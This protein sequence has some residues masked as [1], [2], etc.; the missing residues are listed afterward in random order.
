MRQI[1]RLIYLALSLYIINAGVVIA[2]SSGG[3]DLRAGI[4]YDYISQEY[5]LESEDTY[6]DPDS[7]L[8][9]ALLKKD[10]L[11][12]KKGFFYLGYSS[13]SE[14]SKNIDQNY[15]IG[16]EQTGE[17]FRILGTARIGKTL[18]KSQFVGNF[19]LELKENYKGTADPGEE[20]VILNSNFDYRYR[21]SNMVD[22]RSKIYSESVRFDTVESY[23]YNYSRYGIELGFNY[24]TP[25]FNSISFNSAFEIRD[26]PDSNQLDYALFRGNLGYF[27]SVFGAYLTADLGFESRNYNQL[28][29]RENYFLISLNADT[30]MPLG[31]NYFLR[32]RQNVEYFNFSQN[33][34]INDDY[35]LARF[36]L[37]AGQS[38]GRFSALSTFIGP[39]IELLNTD[40]DYSNDDDY[41]EIMAIFGLDYFG[42][43]GLFLMVENK[44]GKRIYRNKSIYRS[45]FL[46]ERANIIGSMGLFGGLNL[47][48]L[49]SFDLEFHDTQSDNSRLYLISG[50]LSYRF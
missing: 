23:I 2:D 46:F 26:V 39:E 48:I 29:N 17:L 5:F 27:G 30:K 34:F 32:A 11:D 7:S 13:D 12:D 31:E 3:F 36:G 1:I 19:R 38:F 44:F 4:G 18:H 47:D 20:L 25:N 33:D 8:K 21:L 28:D 9:S 14:N 15:E 16:W 40:S 49:L 22:L 42:S 6:L 35:Y 43:K 10:Y 41:T 45:E 37:F 24:F 50:G